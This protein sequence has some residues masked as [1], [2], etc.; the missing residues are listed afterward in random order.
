M[1]VGGSYLVS[2]QFDQLLKK[3]KCVCGGIKK[4]LVHDHGVLT[5][6]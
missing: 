4:A 6:L 1:A 2:F 3:G 5:F